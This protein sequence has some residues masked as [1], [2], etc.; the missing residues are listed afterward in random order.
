MYSMK[1]HLRP[2]EVENFS[3]LEWRMQFARHGSRG[4]RRWVANSGRVVVADRIAL[5]APSRAP[6]W[7]PQPTSARPERDERDLVCPTHGVPVECL[8][9]DGDLLEFV[10]APVVSRVGGSWRVRAGLDKSAERVRRVHRPGLELVV[11][12][13]SDDE[14][15]PRRGKKLGPIQRT[16]PSGERSEA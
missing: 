5:A 14:G 7:M 2:I 1:V 4:T 6:A 12:G 10:G 9:R 3:I 13:R 11:D 15:S 8:A 16:A